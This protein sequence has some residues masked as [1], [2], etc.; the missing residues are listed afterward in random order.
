MHCESFTDPEENLLQYRLWRLRLANGTERDVELTDS[1][2]HGQRWVV[3][4]QGVTSPEAAQL[5]AGAGVCVARAEL[6][7]LASGEFYQADLIG[8]RVLNREGQL[9]GRVEHFVDGPSNTVLVVSGARQHWLPVSPQHLLKVD[10]A[11]GEMLVDW[12]ADF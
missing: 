10:L 7:P 9:L 11:A 3:S 12:P 1:R 2:R 6:P 8:L 4:L 5:L